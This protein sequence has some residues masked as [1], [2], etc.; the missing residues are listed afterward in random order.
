MAKPTSAF[1]KAGPSLVPSPVTAT[2][3][4]CSM[5]V[6]SMMPGHKQGGNRGCSRKCVQMNV[7]VFNLRLT[8]DQCV[9]VSWRGSSQHTEFGPDFVNTFLFN[10]P[11]RWKENEMRV[12]DKWHHRASLNYSFLSL[13]VTV[14]PES[15]ATIHRCDGAKGSKTHCEIGSY[16]LLSCNQF[17]NTALLHNHNLHAAF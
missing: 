15:L 12:F 7:C 1:F 3:C 14:D 4:L 11:V 9:F 13:D 8:F 16:I 2:T 17:N 5:T 10:L 6:L